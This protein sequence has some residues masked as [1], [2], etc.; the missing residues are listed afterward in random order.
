M[1]IKNNREGGEMTTVKQ[2]YFFP[3]SNPDYTPVSAP[4]SDNPGYAYAD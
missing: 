4:R 3:T 1:T 2:H